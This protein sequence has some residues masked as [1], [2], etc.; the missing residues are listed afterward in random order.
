MGHRVLWQ[1]RYAS[2]DRGN[3]PPSAWVVETAC[4]L[5]NDLPVADV[6]GGV[7]RHAVPL[8][9][10]GHRV[11]V[12]DF[13]ERAVRAAIRP[14]RGVAG[15]VADTAALPLREGRFGLVVVTNFLDRAIAPELIALL[16][17]GGRL[18]YETY[19]LE[20]L[21]L[22]RRGLA[23]GPSSP[24]VLL[25]PGELRTLF[26]SLTVEEYA[27]REVEDAAGRRHCARLLARKPS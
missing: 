9:R 14:E 1:E 24:D 22:V 7:G 20:H 16:S 6:A 15:V 2:E 23:R 4:R 10:C 12:V 11:V 8:A 5:P 17:P 3:R 26:P 25:R 19:T 21:D 27:E 13:V 18:I